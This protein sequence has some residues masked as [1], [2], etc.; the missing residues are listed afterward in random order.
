MAD[1]SRCPHFCLVVL[2]LLGL[3]LQSTAFAGQP[4]VAG[5]APDRRPEGAPVPT[6]PPTDAT[7]ARGLHGVATP[8]PPGLDFMAHQGAWH[9]PFTQPGMTGPYDIRGWHAES[10]RR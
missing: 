5:L 9:T 2:S 7:R 6:H 10:A 1:S 8:L 3:C 4:P